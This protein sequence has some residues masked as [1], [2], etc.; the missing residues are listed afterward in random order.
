M[1]EILSTLILLSAAG[2]V[3]YLW[4]EARRQN[5]AKRRLEQAFAAAA[6]QLAKEGIPVAPKPY[7]PASTGGGN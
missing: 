7:E 4:V 2:I 6:P 1:T 3:F 5:V